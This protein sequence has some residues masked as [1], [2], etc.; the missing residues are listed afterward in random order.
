M[1]EDGAFYIHNFPASSARA[2]RIEQLLSSRKAFDVDD[3]KAAQLDLRDLRAAEVLPDLLEI[4]RS[5]GDDRV[6]LAVALLDGW[7]FEA[8]IDAAPPCLY[9]P[10]LDRIWARKFMRQIIDDPVIHAVPTA[11]PGLTRFDVGH[12]LAPG[13]PWLAHREQLI[14]TV[15]QVMADVVDSVSATLGDDP[16]SWRWGDLHQVAFSHRLAKHPPWAGMEV[17]PD[18][19]GG[20]ATTL[21]MAMHMGPGPGRAKAGEVPC[22]VYHGPAFRLV[23]DMADP[24]R[25]QFVIAGGNGGR[26]S[27]PFATDHYAT[28]LNGGYFTVSLVREEI[29]V[30]ETWVLSP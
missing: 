7:D 24:E 21:G 9:Y 6:Q 13:S 2:D 27:S 22:R 30:H 20:S 26:T 3:F 1:G 23:V 29:D 12:F 15:C 17:G 8:Q 18:P 14:E 5:S 4:L 19:I 16:A 28:W 10:F 11:A 25:V